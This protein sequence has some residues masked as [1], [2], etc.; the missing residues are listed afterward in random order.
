MLTIFFLFDHIRPQHQTR[1]MGRAG[2]DGQY[3]WWPFPQDNYSEAGL[4]FSFIH[5][6]LWVGHRV[7]SLCMFWR[8]KHEKGSPGF[9]AFYGG[10]GY[11]GVVPLSRYYLNP[12]LF[13]KR[14]PGSLVLGRSQVTLGDLKKAA[15]RSD[16]AGRSCWSQPVFRMQLHSKCLV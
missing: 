6:Q 11:P 14:S 2:H 15:T 9:Q 4:L 12:A 13:Q 1:D 7:Q 5:R 10:G 16:A 3:L 8:S